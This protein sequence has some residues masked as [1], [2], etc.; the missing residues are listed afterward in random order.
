MNRS[1][2]TDALDNFEA[3]RWRGSVKRAIR[4]KRGQAFLQ[5][6]AKDMDAMPVKELIKG[7]LVNTEGECCTIGV[8]CK[9]RN[10]PI[11][12]INYE[13]PEAVG[14]AVGIARSMAAEIEYQNDEGGYAESQPELWT[15]MRKWVAENIH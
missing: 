3:A 7:E 6:L 8:V 4:G 2:Y 15:R 9:S 5:E 1:G 11:E 12:Q 14:S 10:L 13:D